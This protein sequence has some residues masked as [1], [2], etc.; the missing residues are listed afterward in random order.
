MKGKRMSFLEIF[1]FVLNLAQILYAAL[2]G[3]KTVTPAEA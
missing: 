3:Q 2:K 1:E